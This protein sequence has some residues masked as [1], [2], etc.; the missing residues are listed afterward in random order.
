MCHSEK[1]QCTLYTI[2][3]LLPA[4]YGLMNGSQ[5]FLGME[6]KGRKII[7]EWIKLKP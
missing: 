2:F 7:L 4:A 1:S 3:K 6:T 5:A